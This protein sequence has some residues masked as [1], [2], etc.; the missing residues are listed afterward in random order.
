VLA[1]LHRVLFNHLVKHCISPFEFEQ[2]LK[3]V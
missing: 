2:L 1:V 3:L